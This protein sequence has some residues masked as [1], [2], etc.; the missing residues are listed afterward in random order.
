MLSLNL[1]QK[2]IGCFCMHLIFYIIVGATFIKDF[3]LF[4]DDVTLLIHAG[5][6]S[7][8]CLEIRRYEKNF[9]IRR[10]DDDFNKALEYIHEAEEFVPQV[11]N[12]LEIIQ[13][14]MHL[15]SLTAKLLAYKMNFMGIKDNNTC[16][17][18]T[19]ITECPSWEKIRD[20]G[21]DL[22]GISENLVFYEQEKMNDFIENFKV[23]VLETT[24]FFIIL[25][26]FTVLLLQN[27]I[28]I[29]L[30]TVEKAAINIANGTFS[31]VPVGDK[32]CEVASVLRA[33]NTMVKELEKKQEQLF[34][35]EKLSSIGTL[36][37]GTAHQ[38]NNPLNNISTSC[39]LAL[40]DV[41]PEQ[42]P[43]VVQM[44]ETIN[45]ETQ[46]AGE[47][48]RGLLEFSRANTFSLQRFSLAEVVDKVTRLVDSEIH[49]GITLKTEIPEDIIV[50]IDVQ[51]MVE[52][53]LNLTINAI[54][55]ITEPPGTV[56]IS[57]KQDT[58][59]DQAV[60]TVA[61]TGKGIEKE[62]LQKIFDPFFTTKGAG[63]GTGLGLAVVYGII[64]KQ[65]GTTRVVSE[66]GKGTRFI[67]TLPLFHEHHEEPSI[68][69]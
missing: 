1:R 27:S 8:I 56:C 2:M 6:L 41:D 38:I 15:E 39:Q 68:H 69:T 64:K 47:I 10:D 30:K 66:K 44:L 52:A 50:N 16:Y 25:S 21:Q 26:I 20:L 57:V 59:R 51:K 62:D 4:S 33:F 28:V 55:A 34:Q 65:K 48:V 49:A 37:S 54:Q 67:I 35:A 31:P 17:S 40:E 12:D 63:S 46:R 3:K 14:P 58:E 32:K 36:A 22:V 18:V 43:F 23:L 45:H 42:C 13:N 11:I 5:N 24:A 53:L 61:D 29:P 19:D 7:N 9:V 60:I